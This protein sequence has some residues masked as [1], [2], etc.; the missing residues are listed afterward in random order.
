MVRWCNTFI[1]ES[2]LHV[3]WCYGTFRAGGN[4]LNLRGNWDQRR[5][6]GR[7]EFLKMSRAV[8]GEVWPVRLEFRRQRFLAGLRI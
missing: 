4:N 3:R 8:S 6:I 1:N 7:G 5:G 2:C